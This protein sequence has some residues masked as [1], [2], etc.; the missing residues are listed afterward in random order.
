MKLFLP[1]HRKSCRYAFLF[2]GL[3]YLL[4]VNPAHA[5]EPAGMRG[6]EKKDIR[7]GMVLQAKPSGYSALYGIRLYGTPVGLTGNVSG[8]KTSQALQP[9]IGI[10]FPFSRAMYGPKLTKADV[11]RMAGPSRLVWGLDI[12]GDVFSFTPHH[13]LDGH[14]QQVDSFAA[15]ETVR[16]NWSLYSLSLGPEVRWGGSSWV[17]SLTAGPAF[18]QNQPAQFQQGDPQQMVLYQD[19]QVPS[20][21][22]KFRLGAQGNLH[23]QWY[24]FHELPLGF[25]LKAGYFW[26]QPYTFQVRERDISKVNFNLSPQEIRFQLSNGQIAPFTEKSYSIP[27]QFFNGQLGLSITIKTKSPRDKVQTQSNRKTIKTKSP[28]D[29]VQIQSN[30]VVKPNRSQTS[31]QPVVSEIEEKQKPQQEFRIVLDEPRPNAVFRSQDE[32]P[33]FR[34]H[35]VGTP[36][37]DAQYLLEVFQLDPQGN[38]A[39][40]IAA[41]SLNPGQPYRLPEQTRAELRRLPAATNYYSWKVTETT[42]GTSSGQPLY[43]VQSASCGTIY[44]STHIEC[45]GWDIQTGLPKYQ[46]KICLTNFPNTTSNTSCNANYTSVTPTS[47]SGGTISNIIP[48]FSSSNPLIIS[49]N[50]TGCITFTYQPASLSQT[51]ATFQLNGTWSD[52]L[53]NTVNIL[54][55]DSLPTCICRDC[56]SVNIQIQQP[57]VQMQAADPHLFDI[58]GSVVESPHSVYALEFSV[59][60]FSFTAQPGGCATVD[61]LEHD[62]MIVGTGTTVNNGT[63][64]LIFGNVPIG[65]PNVFKVLKWVSSSPVPAGTPIPFDLVMSL[66]AAAS[67]LDPSCCRIKYHLCLQVKVYYDACRFCTKTICLDFDNSITQKP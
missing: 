22:K 64:G 5:Q 19:Y 14:E 27:N 31:I 62:G 33:A 39:R 13:L 57:Q 15:T 8:M 43:S 11:A 20:D 50:Q 2:S 21:F 29:K 46:V 17:V 3:F 36:P 1:L 44:D 65:N 23:L 28:R 49:P 59:Q 61:G 25:Y 16:K 30:R 47:G 12:H 53:Q 18:T 42:T 6:I 54:A 56:D 41:A 26:Q 51:T 40:R 55:G 66:P 60:S 10:S 52:Q 37:A 35:V 58:T 63:A 38:I 48:S 9:G 24:P 45:D 67:G 32:V 7:R 4:F 34:W